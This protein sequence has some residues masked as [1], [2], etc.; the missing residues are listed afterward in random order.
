M[1][2][3][4]LA[5]KP[6]AWDYG[7]VYA[8]GPILHDNQLWFYY[9]A[10][11]LTHNGY[12]AQPW[13]GPYTTPN[14][15]GKGVRR[16]PPRRL[17]QRRSRVLRPRYPHHP[18]LPPGAGRP[19]QKSMSTPALASSAT[20]SL[21]TPAARYRG[22]TVADC[23]PIREDTLDSALSWNGK[24]GWPGVGDDRTARY[25]QLNHSEFYVKLRFYISPG[26]K[27]YALTIDP[28]EVT[29]WLVSLK[30]TH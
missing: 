2:P 13:Q 22:F 1:N 20:S 19:H 9:M 30:T 29:E 23:D 14:R 27:L 28:P 11:N 10:G 21:K 15:R 4:S 26:T 8:D 24:P 16:P 17:R 3:S 6:G 7:M 18:P 25:P 5:A 12:S